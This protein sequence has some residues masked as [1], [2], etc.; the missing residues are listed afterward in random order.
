MSLHIA[1][2][3]LP[4]RLRGHATLLLCSSLLRIH[5]SPTAV[6]MCAQSSYFSEDEK[7]LAPGERV[8]CETAQT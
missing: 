2:L 4:H 1:P 8:V 3:S 5:L 6:E 7:Y